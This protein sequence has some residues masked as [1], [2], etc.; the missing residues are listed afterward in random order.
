[1]EKTV[2]KLVK[3]QDLELKNK[4]VLM[5]ADYNV[6]LKDGVISDDTRIVASLKTV[7]YLLSQNCKVVIMAHLGRPKG[8][9]DPKY[10]LK[11]VAARLQELTGA[12]VFFA[13]AA[14]G[15]EAEKVV[16]SARN[17][18]I[19][20]LENIRF[21]KE[22]TGNDPEFAK[23]LAKYGDFFVQEGFGV[24]HR[25]HASTD[26]ITRYLPGAIGF[27][28]Q[29]ELEYLDRA[30]VNPARP[31]AAII[32]GAKV[33]DKI[34]VL[35]SLLEKVDMLVIGGG[36]AYTFLAAQNTNIGKSL[37]EADK[38]E[39]AKKII[40]KAH[41][42]NVDLILPADH[43]VVKEIGS[44]DV[45]VTQSMAIPDDMI[46]IDIGPRTEL[47]L[48]EKMKGVKT[49]FWNGPVGIFEN[50]DYAKGTFALARV[51]ANET[52]KG[53]ISIIGGGDTVNAI[54][55][56]HVGTE[57]ISHCSTG[58]GASLE[59]VEGKILPGLLALSKK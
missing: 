9:P 30:M 53:A 4:S 29:K 27:L 41:Q 36:M 48:S 28:V 37:L 42:N 51:V 2:L 39:E 8:T 45:E 47:M 6:P 55:K 26:A 15:P 21:Y 14:I 52:K 49:I 22:E 33:S 13:P 12:K 59:F 20:L 44:R 5:R 19:V 25:A 40:L 54:K 7:K 31:F 57:N 46:G 23:K 3:V 1:M 56:S 43:R 38:L 32:G 58:G 34:S 18:E 11:P 17:G 10:S 24:V 50:P 16:E 35:E